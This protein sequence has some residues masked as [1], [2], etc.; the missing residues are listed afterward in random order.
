MPKVG[1]FLKLR[2][3]VKVLAYNEKIIF[4]HERTGVERNNKIPSISN[5][6]AIGKIKCSG[7]ENDVKK[8]QIKTNS[9][10]PQLDS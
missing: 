4:W 6:L 1:T 8:N 5:S 3:S 2:H 7:N 9:D 10:D